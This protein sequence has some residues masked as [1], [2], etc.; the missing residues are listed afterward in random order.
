MLTIRQQGPYM[1]KF[2]YNFWKDVVHQV[3]KMDNGKQIN[4]M[5]KNNNFIHY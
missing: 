5:R 3:K 1:E 4:R 2:S